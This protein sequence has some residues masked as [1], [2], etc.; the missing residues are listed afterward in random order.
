[1]CVRIREVGGNPILY[2]KSPNYSFAQHL[3]SK[4]SDLYVCELG[5]GDRGTKL[6]RFDDNSAETDH[7]NAF[8]EQLKTLKYGGS[9]TSAWAIPCYASADDIALSS[10]NVFCIGTSIDQSQYD[11]VSSSMA[12]NI[13]LTITP[14]SNLTEATT[15]VKWLT[16]YADDGHSFLGL[17][18]T[19]INDDR[20]LVL[21]EESPDKN[22]AFALADMQDTLSSGL[23]HYC[24]IDGQGNIISEEHTAPA[25]ISVNS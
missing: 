25:M 16:N 7:W 5:E 11:N 24:F 3:D 22:N 14:I 13:Y 12:H 10:D 2:R 6:S 8:S 17:N 23:I 15:T 19:R 9:H 18:I 1:M 20:F 21:W 4:D